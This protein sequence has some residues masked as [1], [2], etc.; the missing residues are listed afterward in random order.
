MLRLYWESLDYIDDEDLYT[1][2]N[3]GFRL[4]EVSHVYLLSDLS[5]ISPTALANTVGL[6]PAVSFLQAVT[7][8]FLS[9]GRSMFGRACHPRTELWW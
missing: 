3:S 5:D 2:F 1:F 6:L 4:Q 9:P 7:S 8:G